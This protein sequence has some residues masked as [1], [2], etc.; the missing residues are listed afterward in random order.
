MPSGNP[1]VKVKE[2]RVKF[3]K[4]LKEEHSGSQAAETPKLVQEMP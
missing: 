1:E 4:L 3:L 2:R